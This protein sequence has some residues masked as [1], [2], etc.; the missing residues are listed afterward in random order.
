MKHNCLFSALLLLV[1]LFMQGCNKKEDTI[2]KITLQSI[3]EDTFTYKGGLGSIVAESGGAVITATSSNPDW[4]R[5]QVLESTVLFNITSYTGNSD[6]AATITIE[7]GVLEPLV[8]EITQSKFTGLI[9]SPTTLTFSDTERTLL[10]T[11]TAS[12]EYTVTLTEN[13]NSTFSFTK[14]ES[15]VQFAVSKAP[16]RTDVSGRAVLTPNDGGE[17]VIITLIL[18]RKSVYDHLIGT[19]A[20]V[21]T[22]SIWSECASTNYSF[23]F[24]VKE[25]QSSYYVTIDQ[26]LL[27]T[28]RRLTIK[29]VNGKLTIPCGQELGNNGSDFVTLHYNGTLN[30]SGSYILTSAGQVAWGAEPV[31][32]ESAGTITL[33]FTDNGHGKSYVATTLAIW[34][35]TGSYFNFQSGAVVVGYNTLTLT[36]TYNE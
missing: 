12:S 11:V 5:V 26:P 31:F 22:C 15:G 28:A 2:T 19:W 9:V 6:R 36:K 33:T 7:A 20:T 21:G 29:Y 17:S 14:T 16:G 23:T 24:S 34:S 1:I 8:V 27:G 32:D 3:T 13:P 30:G 25:S 18:P 35:C 10:A 4:C